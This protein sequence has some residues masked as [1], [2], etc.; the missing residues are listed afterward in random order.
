MVRFPV[1]RI[2]DSGIANQLRQSLVLY[3]HAHPFQP[4]QR[5]YHVSVS[6]ASLAELLVVVEDEQVNLL[7]EIEIAAPGDVVRLN[8]PYSHQSTSMY[9]DGLL[10]QGNMGTLILLGIV[11]CRFFI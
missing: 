3:R 9:L 4:R 5:L 10:C 11:V 6:P 8:N 7:D 2:L 1:R